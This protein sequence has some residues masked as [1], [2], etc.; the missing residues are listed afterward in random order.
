[1]DNQDLLS[2]KKLLLSYKQRL[3]K[4]II[5]RSNK[6][7]IP[8]KFYENTINMNQDIIKLNKALAK[9]DQYHNHPNNNEK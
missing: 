2:T 7:R 8:K 5:N 6:L 3:E 4:E 9:L 1:L